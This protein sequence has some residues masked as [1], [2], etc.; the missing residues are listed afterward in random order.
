MPPSPLHISRLFSGGLI[1]NLKCA[2]ACRHCLYGCSG[3]WPDDYADSA[4]TRANLSVIKKLGRPSVHIGGGEPFL[5]PEKL[6]TVLDVAREVGV[7]I[8]YIETNSSWVKDEAW[9]DDVLRGVRAQGV[10]CLLLSMDPFHNEYIPF[11]KVKKLMAACR[12]TGLDV[13]P[14]RAEF[15]EDLQRLDVHRT[16]TLDEFAEAFGD[17]YI[18]NLINRYGPTERGRSLDLVRP[19][20]RHLPADTILDRNET[21]CREL[22]STSHFHIDLYGNY[23]PGLCSGL[24]IHR[25]DLGQPVADDTYP[26]LNALY[27][28]GIRGLY[29]L[30]TQT[31]A[32]QVRP[33]GYMSK[34]DLCFHIRKYLVTESTI[35][36]PDLQPADYYIYS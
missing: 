35:K 1:V 32:F 7:T 29:E 23:L 13:F 14:W 2:S 4:A 10:Y 9:T 17:G 5:H 12:R 27:T 21:P 19:Y 20:R 28:R 8:D 11:I 33:E 22:D 36:S 30:A 18:R 34:C 24:A 6:F 26:F 16:H 3:R 15:A 31:A 25:E